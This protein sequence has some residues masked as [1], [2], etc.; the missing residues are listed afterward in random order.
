MTPFNFL[1]EHVKT[2]I[3]I[4][5]VHGVGLFAIVDIEKGTEVFQKWNGETEIYSMTYG[6]ALTL[7][8]QILQVV[9]K[10]FANNIV[11][12]NS[13]IYYRLT[14]GVNFLISEPLCFLNTAYEKGNVDSVTGISINN[15]KIGAELFGNYDNSSQ[16]I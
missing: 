8:K 12:N 11:N 9:L 3:G 2:E 6:E 15:I 10:S 13:D 1:K 16:V 14:N 4:S 5:P 7:P